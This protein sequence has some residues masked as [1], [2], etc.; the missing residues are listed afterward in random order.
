MEVARHFSGF[1]GAAFVTF[2]ALLA[3][4]SSANAS[5]LAS[6]RI[7]FALGRDSILPQ[8]LNEVH[9]RFLTPYRPIL[10][11]G[12]LTF[13]L[14]V[15]AD[16][17][18]LSNSASVLMLLN[19][20]LIN[21]SV[22]IMRIVPPDGY[23]PSFKSPGFPYLH[24]IG[25]ITSFGVIMVAAPIARLIAV[26]LIV[27]SFVWFISWGNKKVEIQGAVENLNLR[28]I[29][30]P[31]P[32]T[33]PDELKSSPE[34]IEEHELEKDIYR[35]LV[36]M[37]NPHHEIS[38]LKLSS[39]I[40]KSQPQEGEI[41]L[42]NILKIPEQTPLD[43]AKYRE[44]TVDKRK[45]VYQEMLSLAT[46]FGEKE[47]IV[48]NPR[49][50]YSRERRKTIE[51]FIKNEKIN[52][53]LLGWHDPMNVVNIYNSLVK[54]LI[55]NAP[56]PVGVLKDRGVEKLEN[57]LVP[58]R[59]SEHAY[60]GVKVASEFIK[61]TEGKVTVLRIVKPGIDP[62]EEKKVA[63]EEIKELMDNN[64]IE[65]KVVFADQVVNGI[66][67]EAANNDYDIVF[68]GASK[69]W[70]LKNMLFGSI[71]DIVA[72]ELDI[73]ILMLRSF[74]QEVKKEVLKDDEEEL[75]KDEMVPEK[76]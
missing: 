72:E 70:T 36:P 33:Q 14:I 38:M 40:A 51:N 20:A 57:I 9:P 31:Q 8:G 19:Y 48:I 34:I 6:S 64:N 53:L 30:T 74:D 49:I 29:F 68:M 5:I 60:W 13:L 27:I 71:P 46:E 67:S 56:C 12:I 52:F 45:K 21:F 22:L 47:E 1:I 73:S 4:A 63:Q 3:T 28:K 59:G 69:E 26:I 66:L 62:E 25:G 10:L 2:A 39:K 65:I 11:T 16:V 18:L 76:F 42:L 75:K 32:S 61:N 58:Y 23:E 35:I 54:D 44:K 41:N 15:T 7:S 43:L 50:M 17:E 24:L 37:A 55:R